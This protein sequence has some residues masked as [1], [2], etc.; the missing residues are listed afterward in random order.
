MPRIFNPISFTSL[1]TPQGTYIY[2]LVP[3]GST[4]LAAISSTDSLHIFN[5]QTLQQIHTI[6][7]IHTGGV[8]CLKALNSNTLV[9]AGR[10]GLVRIWDTR[11]ALGKERAKLMCWLYLHLM[12]PFCDCFPE[13]AGVS[14][15]EDK[16][17]CTIN[18][19]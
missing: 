12:I 4:K 6:P 19:I 10:D 2:D 17:N 7:D 18:W 5:P 16:D 14:F 8:T 3:Q 15:G 1:S 11:V 13:S 9:T